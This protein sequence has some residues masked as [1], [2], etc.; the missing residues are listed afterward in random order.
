MLK[1]IL[2]PPN[3]T[4]PTLEEHVN[5]YLPPTLRVWKISRVQASFN[6]RTTCDGRRYEYVFP[7][8]VLLPP[9]P[10]TSLGES[11]S[12]KGGL[13]FWA[14]D[15]K[16]NPSAS[17]SDT[18]ADK[19]W[20]TFPL[21]TGNHAEE[22]RLRRAFRLGSTPGLLDAMREA[23]QQFIGSH[24]FHNYT[25]EKAFTDRSAS[26]QMKSIEVGSL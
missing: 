4:L 26:R 12:T 9:R 24:N 6:P 15:T 14:E 11:A 10:G 25:T 3:M 18:P 1:L 7:S 22:M 17:P 8:Y 13:K 5:S 20:Q 19:F 16:P 21:E 2:T 23:A